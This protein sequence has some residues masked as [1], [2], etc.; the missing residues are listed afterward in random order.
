[1]AVVYA[2]FLK[3]AAQRLGPTLPLSGRQEA[4]AMEADSTAA[5]PLQGLV[6]S[7]T[8]ARSPH[9]ASAFTE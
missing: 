5:C 6:R 4:I 2:Y 8:F 3:S 7:V 1:L 9:Q